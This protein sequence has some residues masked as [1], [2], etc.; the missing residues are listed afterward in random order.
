[1]FTF[2]SCIQRLTIGLIY[3]INVYIYL[4]IYT[5]NCK[6]PIESGRPPS[7]PRKERADLSDLERYADVIT[8]YRELLKKTALEDDINLQ[9]TRCVVPQDREALLE[10][11]ADPKNLDL[12]A[13]AFRRVCSG[14]VSTGRLFAVQCG[15]ALTD[16]AAVLDCIAA[17]ERSL[18]TAYSFMTIGRGRP[19]SEASKVKEALKIIGE[20]RASDSLSLRAA[21]QHDLAEGIL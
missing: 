14:Y 4:V 15:A 18:T 13:A 2:I 16:W 20:V 9:S 21:R 6:E 12:V 7:R 11:V 8:A 3:R 10:W 19:I 17:A 1:M 5:P